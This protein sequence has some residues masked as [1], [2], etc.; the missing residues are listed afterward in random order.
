VYLFFSF[1]IYFFSCCHSHFNIILQYWMKLT[2]SQVWINLGPLLYHFADTYGQDDVR[3]FSHTIAQ[4]YVW[5]LYY[6][7]CNLFV[8]NVHWIKFGRC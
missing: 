2:P 7:I 3:F 1:L 6:L 8:G 5:S 4:S